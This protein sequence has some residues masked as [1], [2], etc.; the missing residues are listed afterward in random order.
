ML[1]P[2]QM[3]EEPER[4]ATSGMAGK[5]LTA[6]LLLRGIPAHGPLIGLTV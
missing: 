1:S 2:G 5:L 3:G 4:M 6:I